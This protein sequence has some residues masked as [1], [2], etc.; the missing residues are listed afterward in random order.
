MSIE[1]NKAIAERFVKAFD[2]A[3]LSC[4]IVQGR[5]AAVALLGALATH[6]L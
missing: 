6:N 4:N 1:S 2:S 5:T 3:S